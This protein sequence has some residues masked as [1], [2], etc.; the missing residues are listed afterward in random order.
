[1]AGLCHS[2]R[3]IDVAMALCHRNLHRER[4]RERELILIGGPKFVD[5]ILS[6][7]MTRV[8]L[9]LSLVRMPRKGLCKKDINRLDRLDF[10]IASG[11]FSY[12]FG[13]KEKKQPFLRSKKLKL[14][15]LKLDRETERFSIRGDLM[16]FHEILQDGR[17]LE[18][19]LNPL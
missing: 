15:W 14:R 4:E 3:R 1:M 9:R 10:S 7:G 19:G 2:S 17:L 8:L 18:M 16:R 12:R 11:C 6:D 13:S 5:Y